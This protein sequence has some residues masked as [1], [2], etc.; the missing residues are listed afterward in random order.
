MFVYFILF[1]NKYF[2]YRVEQV[3]NFFFYYYQDLKF[4]SSFALDN[5][6]KLIKWLNPKIQSFKLNIFRFFFPLVFN[7]DNILN[8]SDKWE[9]PDLRKQLVNIIVKSEKLWDIRIFI[10]AKIRNNIFSGKKKL[11]EDSEV[12]EMLLLALKRHSKYAFELKYQN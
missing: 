5:Y 7:N 9:F 2:S 6:Q 11:W 12:N 10:Y 3:L 4:D 8:E 1:L